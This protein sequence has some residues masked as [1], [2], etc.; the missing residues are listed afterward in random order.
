[1]RLVLKTIYFFSG[2]EIGVSPVSTHIQD[3]DP[4]YAVDTIPSPDTN[5]GRP[6]GTQETHVRK[7]TRSSGR[8]KSRRSKRSKK[9]RRK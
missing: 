8:K 9:K 1:M 6:H 5:E 2:R 4:R 7:A 3:Y